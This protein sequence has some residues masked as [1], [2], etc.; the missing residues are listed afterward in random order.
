MTQEVK[1]IKLATAVAERGKTVEAATEVIS[2]SNYIF[3][4]STYAVVDHL[5]RSM[6]QITLS[7][8]ILE[9]KL[10]QYASRFRAMTVANDRADE[11]LA[12][13]K[14][15]YYRAKRHLK[16]ERLKEIMN[17]LRGAGL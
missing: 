6:L 8:V 7:E 16:D 12:E 13:L 10:A 11:S 5:E 1:T 17:G 15:Q 14:T 4:P 2:E 9:S 3:E